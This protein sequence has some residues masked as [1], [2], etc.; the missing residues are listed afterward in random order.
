[1]SRTDAQNGVD[2]TFNF[3]FVRRE[4]GGI[5]NYALCML[6]LLRGFSFA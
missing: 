6:V 3:L 5:A 4:G 2:I 1:M